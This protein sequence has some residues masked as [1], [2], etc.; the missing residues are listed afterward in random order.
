MSVAGS[1]TPLVQ[2]EHGRPAALPNDPE[3]LRELVEALLKQLTDAQVENQKLKQQLEALKRGLWGRKSEKLDANQLTMFAEL[4]AKHGLAMPQETPAPE[5]VEASPKPNGTKKAGGRSLIAPH[6]PRR[7]ITHKLSEQQLKCPKCG[8]PRTIIGYESR[9]RLEIVPASVVVIEDRQEKGFCEPCEGEFVTAPK[10]TSAIEKVGAGPGLLA[11]LV[12]SKIDDHL[13]VYRQCEILRR[14][15]VEVPAATVGRWLL[16]VAEALRP[17][18]ERM[19][20][21]VKQSKVIETDE[22]KVP[23][24]QAG[25]GETHK[26]RMWVFRGDFRQPY[27]VYHYTPTKESKGPKDWLRGYRGDLQADA[28]PGFDQLYVED[29]STGTKIREVACNAHA[30]RKFESIKLNFPAQALTALRFY[31]RLYAIEEQ[32]TRMSKHRR[33]RL[34]RK[35]ARPILAEFTAWLELIQAQELPNSEL[36]KAVRYVDSNWIALTRYVNE[37][38]FSIDNNAAERAMRPVAIGRKNWMF[39]GHDEGAEALAILYTMVESAKRAGLNP[40]TWLHDVLDRIADLPANRLEDLLPDRWKRRQ[41][42]SARHAMEQ[43]RRRESRRAT[44]GA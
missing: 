28:Y 16:M 13:P 25:R 41:V 35:E 40:E 3:L 12:V 32:A 2:D 18:S 33:R 36:G 8:R 10:P 17:L 22:T 20:Q 4:L 7:I 14:H 26:G 1:D 43:A 42:P 5:A 37:P 38:R 24:Q 15:G 21:R 19:A 30:R 44:P 27:V 23:V 34:R 31:R 39:A 9:S 11:H 6:L 29:P